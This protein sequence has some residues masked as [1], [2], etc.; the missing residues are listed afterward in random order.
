MI[1]VNDKYVSDDLEITFE[2]FNISKD[3]NFD[4]F[5]NFQINK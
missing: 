1:N 3:I 2:E 4:Q 5:H